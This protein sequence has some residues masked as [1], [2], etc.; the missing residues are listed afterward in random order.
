MYIFI[1][2]GW[3]SGMKPYTELPEKW[4]SGIYRSKYLMVRTVG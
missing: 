2:W 4:G 1:S 3:I